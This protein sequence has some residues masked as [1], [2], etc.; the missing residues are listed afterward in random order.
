MKELLE[1]LQL[2]FK[3]KIAVLVGKAKK[4]QK[5]ESYKRLTMYLKILM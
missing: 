2:L 1:I 4:N 5:M 3:F